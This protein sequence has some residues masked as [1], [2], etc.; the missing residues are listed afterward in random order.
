MA[1]APTGS[2]KTLAF[3]LPILH[4]LK[5]PEKVGYR[6]VIISPTRELATQ[7]QMSLLG[8]LLQADGARRND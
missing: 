4:D 2:G 3:V 5:G 1:M 6:A 7:V 8:A